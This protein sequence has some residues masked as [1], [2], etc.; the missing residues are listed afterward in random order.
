M[1]LPAT[2]QHISDVHDLDI[3]PVL[4]DIA[5]QMHEAAE[6]CGDEIISAAVYR[7]E[8]FLFAHTDG[9]RFEFHGEGAAKAATYF[10]IIHFFDLQ[11]FYVR[12]K[13]AWPF[14]D[15]AFPQSPTGIVVSAGTLQ[16]SAEVG[17]MQHIREEFR[18]FV[19]IFAQQLYI[20]MRSRIVEQ[21]AVVITDEARAGAAGRYNVIVC[22][23]VFEK[24]GSHRAAFIL[25]TG[26]ERG[27]ATTG[28]LCVII[29][30]TSQLLQHFY[31]VESGF[32]EELVY[33]AWYEKLY[34]HAVS[35]SDS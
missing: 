21:L 15:A 11:A 23:E 31:H 16:G 32:G 28:L 12:Q 13:L 19:E 5:L 20:V 25:V 35:V 3:V 26:I 1:L 29:H 7:V 27:L 24:L 2:G 14:L 10:A 6:V 18:E 33:E 17:H 4:F 9:D 34:V 30:V 22:M 8:H